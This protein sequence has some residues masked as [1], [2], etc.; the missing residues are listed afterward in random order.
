M[1]IWIWR[2][3]LFTVLTILT[4]IGGVIYILTRLVWGKKVDIL[5]KWY[6]SRLLFFLGVYV[7][8]TFFVVPYL[9]PRKPL[10][11][12][13][14]EGLEPVTML[15]IFLNRHYVDAEL[16]EAIHDVAAKA[17]FTIQYMDANFPFFDDFPLLPH[18]SHDDGEK[19]DLAFEYSTGDTD[20]EHDETLTFIGYGSFEAAEGDEYNAAADCRS[21]GFA[22]YGMTGIIPNWNTDA[23]F[24]ARRTKRLIEQLV[25]HPSI[26]KIFIEPHLKSRLGLGSPKIRFHGC[27]AVRH[28]DHIHIQL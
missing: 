6:Q 20:M 28:D 24:D 4:Q 27:H 14:E 21:Q 16:Y 25:A 1:L 22:Q 19:L 13:A 7:L 8:S 9:S 17:D 12:H 15:T 10:P 11:I 18:L 26:N 23:R 2:I 5:P 3:F